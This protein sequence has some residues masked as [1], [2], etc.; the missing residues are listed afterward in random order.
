MFA[1]SSQVG[2]QCFARLRRRDCFK[3]NLGMRDAKTQ[4]H[5]F[6]QQLHRRVVQLEPQEVHSRGLGFVFAL[7]VFVGN[8]GDARQVAH[9]RPDTAFQPA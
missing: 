3:L 2:E 1:I 8:G 9:L 4:L 7:E 6:A 5:T